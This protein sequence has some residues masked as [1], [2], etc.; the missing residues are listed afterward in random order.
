M[1]RKKG[2]E[3]IT[4]TRVDEEAGEIVMRIVRVRMREEDGDASRREEWKKTE[5]GRV[6]RRIS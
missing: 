3:V 4:M 2:V 6:G 5:A 1:K